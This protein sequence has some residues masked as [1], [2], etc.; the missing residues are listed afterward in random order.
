MRLKGCQK[1]HKEIFTDTE[2]VRKR[3]YN[4]RNKLR[5]YECITDRYYFYGKFMHYYYEKILEELHKEFFL[6]EITI[7]EIINKQIDQLQELK[8]TDPDKKFFKQKWP[9]LNWE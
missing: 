9:H 4:P 8:N 1:V 7:S 6:A 5:Q 2:V 3:S